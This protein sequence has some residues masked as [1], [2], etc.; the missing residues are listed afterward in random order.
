MLL[1]KSVPLGI[2]ALT[3]AVFSRGVLTYSI[4]LGF[5]ADSTVGIPDSLRIKLI[6]SATSSF[7]SACL[8]PPY[9]VPLTTLESSFLS[10]DFF[11]HGLALASFSAF[12]SFKSSILLSLTVYGVPSTANSFSLFAFAASS[13]IE[14]LLPLIGASCVLAK[15]VR[16]FAY[17]GSVGSFDSYPSVSSHDSSTGLASYTLPSPSGSIHTPTNSSG[18]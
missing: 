13:A 7:S 3:G 6:D 8:L 2:A 10:D 11:S 4:S 15:S 12:A 16:L 14:N 1:F 5:S 18:E 17:A 9:C